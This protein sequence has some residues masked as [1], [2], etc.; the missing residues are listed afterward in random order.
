MNVKNLYFLIAFLI[1]IFPWSE[2][3]CFG[4]NPAAS[5]DKVAAQEAKMTAGSL[6]ANQQAKGQ[7]VYMFCP[8]AETLYKEKLLWYAH[9]GWKSDTPSFVNHIVVFVGAQWIGVNVGKIICLYTGGQKEAFPVAIERDNLTNSPVTGS[10][11]KN[12]GGYKTCH[13]SKVTDCPFV[14]A[15]QTGVEVKTDIY[16]GLNKR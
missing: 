2:G 12:L 11:G 1:L 9:G 14:S 13:G 15:V 10:W 4:R 16:K 8:K 5:A 7:E 3:W 6:P